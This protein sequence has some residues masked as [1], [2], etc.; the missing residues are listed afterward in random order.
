MIDCEYLQNQ[1]AKELVFQTHIG[2]GEVNQGHLSIQLRGEM[3]SGQSGRTEQ[4]ETLCKC[5]LHIKIRVSALSATESV[6]LSHVL[7]KTTIR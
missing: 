4:P 6:S 5:H 2:D 1:L 7:Q 3:G